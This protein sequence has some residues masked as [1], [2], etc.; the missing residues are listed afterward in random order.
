MEIGPD[1]LPY[2]ELGGADRVDALA[3]AF[4][5]EMDRNPAF[6]MVRKLHPESLEESREKFRLFL[7]GWLGGPDLYVQKHGHPRL[8]MRHAPFPIGEAERDQWLACMAAAMDHLEI[9]GD[10]RAFLDARFA[11]V[12]DF[13]RNQPG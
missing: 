7:S 2:D 11:H 4:Y 12:A 13:M 6:E 9:E 10:I 3:E 5:D 8:R 1:R